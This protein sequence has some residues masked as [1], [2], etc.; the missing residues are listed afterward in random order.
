MHV[1]SIITCYT[2]HDYTY[3]KPCFMRCGRCTEPMLKTLPYNHILILPC[4]ANIVTFPCEEEFSI[5][6]YINY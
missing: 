4:F 3:N 6:N 5:V 2:I 1:V